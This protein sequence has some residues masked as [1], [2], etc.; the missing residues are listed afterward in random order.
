M[1]IGIAKWLEQKLDL[2]R[3]ATEVLGLKG[4]LMFHVALTTKST[5]GSFIIF[6]ALLK[7]L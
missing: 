5:T 2:N 7:T 3:F 1:F 4:L 6:Q